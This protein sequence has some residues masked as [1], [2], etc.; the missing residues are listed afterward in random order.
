MKQIALIGL[1]TAGWLLAGPSKGNDAKVSPEI[2]KSNDAEVDVLLVYEDN[3][4]DSSRLQ[5]EEKV[6]AFG[7]RNYRNFQ[8]AGVGAVRANRAL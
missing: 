1:M 3:D 2:L 4:D 8:G 6:R 5:R 7:G